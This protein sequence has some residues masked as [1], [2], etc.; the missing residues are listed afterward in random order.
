MRKTLGEVAVMC[1]GNLVNKQNE[2]TVIHGVIRDSRHMSEGCLFIPIVGENY[3]G[4]AFVAEGLR[5]GAG[6]ALWQRDRGTPPEGAIIEVDDTLEALQKLSKAYLREVGSKVVGITGSNGKT[7]TKDMI[8]ALL[9]TTYKVH[10][11]V[12]NYNNHIGLPLTILAMDMDVDIIVLEMGMNARHEIEFLAAI[13]GPDVAVITNIGEAHLLQLGSREEIARAKAEISSG[14]K[15]E[16]L[17][18]YNGDEPLISEVLAESTTIKPINMKTWTF[19]INPDNDEYPM[20]MLNHNK[21]VIFTTN[22][23]KEQGIDLPLLG[24]HNVVN[25]LAALAVARHFNVTEENIHKG[26]SHLRLTAMRIEQVVLPT[27]LTIL[28]DAYNASPSSMKAAI[29][30]LQSMKGYRTKIAVLGDMLELGLQENEF[31]A[32]IGSYLTA[33]KVNL[34]YTY[35]PLSAYTAEAAKVHLPESSVY[36]FEDKKELISHLEENLQPRDIVLFKA[37]RGMKLEEVVDALKEK[38]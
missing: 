24:R 15:S 23:H 11:T 17:L 26:L 19:G 25:C 7:T 30:V 2:D 36:A 10:K 6:G 20:G 14:L 1:G 28:N 34:L 18:I 12:G 31:H 8:A 4:H 33:D 35:G 32:E 38:F 5:T 22:V 27:G 9:E 13:A 21:G 3:D 29:D 37:S 16:G